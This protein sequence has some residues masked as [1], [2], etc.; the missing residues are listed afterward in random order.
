LAKLTP[1]NPNDT[2]SYS[3]SIITP[4]E[5]HGT[6][7]YLNGKIVLEISALE[8]DPLLSE[9]GSK[10]D[11]YYVRP[12]YKLVIECDTANNGK[13]IAKVDEVYVN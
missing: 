13:F 7:D 8:T 3:F 4:L 9:L 1:L 5:S 10:A 2:S 6:S 11:R 12:M